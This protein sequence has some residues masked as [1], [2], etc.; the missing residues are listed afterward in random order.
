M[1]NESCC[2]KS[3][4]INL[5]NEYEIRLF[6]EFPSLTTNT[7]LSECL[8]GI[9]LLLSGTISEEAI[10]TYARS[11][12]IMADGRVNLSSRAI[13]LIS[14]ILITLLLILSARDAQY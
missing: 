7:P 9:H 1:D 3:S 14:L 12:S 2:K 4:Q 5:R 8:S 13:L 6:R 10:E 11:G